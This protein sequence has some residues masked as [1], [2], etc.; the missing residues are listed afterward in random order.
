[1]I[2]Y[3][4]FDREAWREILGEAHWKHYNALREAARETQEDSLQIE[5]LRNVLQEHFWKL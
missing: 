2:T 3:E 5:A 4:K 1:M